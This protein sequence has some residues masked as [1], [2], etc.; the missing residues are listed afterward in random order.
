MLLAKVRRRDSSSTISAC[1]VLLELGRVA[2][3]RGDGPRSVELYESALEACTS[4]EEAK[5]L[6]T[7]LRTAG[8]TSLLNRLLTARLD[9]AS[10]PRERAFVLSEL[11]DLRET[12]EEF[13]E[14]LEY[15]IEAVESAPEFAE[16]HEAADAL[17]RRLD[18]LSV[19]EGLLQRLNANA[20][21][22]SLIHI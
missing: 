14:A 8:K 11:A 21:P 13:D 9:A 7:R 18:K 2:E 20:R 1:E 16:F 3:T 17:C 5:S 4:D 6:Q 19:Y 15:R 22:L 10:T 12:S